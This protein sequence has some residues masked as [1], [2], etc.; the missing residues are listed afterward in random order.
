MIAKAMRRDRRAGG[1]A[2]T[3]IAAMALAGLLLL[4]STTP[5]AAQGPA[6]G[7]V[8]V[9]HAA[10]V[11]APG[12]QQATPAGG[13]R[14]D[15]A[16]KLAEFVVFTEGMQRAELLTRWVDLAA[17]PCLPSPPPAASRPAPRAGTG[18][19]RPAATEPPP[20]P[21]TPDAVVAA[22]D[23]ALVWLER[24]EAASADDRARADMAPE[25]FL[26]LGEVGLT[27]GRALATLDGSPSPRA[28]AAFA[29]GRAAVGRI[30]RSSWLVQAGSGRFDAVIAEVEAGTAACP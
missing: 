12:P 28:C 3:M 25:L 23:G 17:A 2:M 22:C 20:P 18:P 11:C 1:P 8:M 26:T 24:F 21:P 5:T 6:V 19:A 16:R 10:E 9:D 4:A 15:A 7:A 13:R 14:C 30:D 29:A 27:R